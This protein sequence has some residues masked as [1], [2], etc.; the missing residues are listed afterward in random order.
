MVPQ[1]AK[2]YWRLD[3]NATMIDLLKAVRADEAGHRFAVSLWSSKRRGLIL[4]N[5]CRR[6][7]N[8]TLANLDTKNDFNPFGLRHPDAIMQGT[9]P[10]ISRE[11]SLRWIKEVEDEFKAGRQSSV[12]VDGARNM[13]EEG[14]E[15]RP[16]A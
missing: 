12:F 6:F 15:G 5:V 3:E 16:S 14:K 4:D 2:D 1:I 13:I 8:H 10:G 7:V 9:L 11:E